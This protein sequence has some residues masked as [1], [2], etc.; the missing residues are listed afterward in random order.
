MPKYFWISIGAVVGII[1]V[2]FALTANRR[3]QSISP[4]A[5]VSPI[6]QSSS[7]GEPSPTAIASQN[8][9]FSNPK[10]SAHYEGNTPTHGAVLAAPPINIVIDFNFDLATG[11]SMTITHDGK[12]YGVGETTIDAN[13]LVLRRSF[14]QIAIDGLYTVDYKA[15]WPDKSCHTGSF[16]FAIDRTLVDRENYTNARNQKEVTVHLRQYAF[17]PT[18]LRIKTGTRVMWVNDDPDTH[19]I[20]TDSHPAHTYYV[21]QNSKA[22][23]KND[24]FELTFDQPGLY[25]YHCSAHADTM[26]ATIIVES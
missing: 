12:D 18:N 8:Y 25:L 6:Q 4:V 24:T 20:N 2:V 7:A 5:S 22:L 9:E 19:Y 10:K 17:S 1:I 16:Q 26:R 15:C 11:S 23:S 21:K 3:S 14:D 13:K